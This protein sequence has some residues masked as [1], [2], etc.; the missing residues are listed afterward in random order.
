MK[1]YT[2]TEREIESIREEIIKV[3]RNINKIE[4]D[5]VFEGKC[6]TRVSVIKNSALNIDN[7]MKKL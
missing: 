4:E 6:V 5:N 2:I 7:I 3:I 1:T